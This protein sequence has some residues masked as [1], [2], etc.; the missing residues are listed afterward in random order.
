MSRLVRAG[1]SG[2]RSLGVVLFLGGMDM[3]METVMD[4]GVRGM[5]MDMDI[6][7]GRKRVMI[8]AMVRDRG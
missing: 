4:T 1:I 8:M 3:D 6:A 5:I 7:M 2:W